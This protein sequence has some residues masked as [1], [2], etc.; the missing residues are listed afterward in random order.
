MLSDLSLPN[1]TIISLVETSSF[2]PGDCIF[3]TVGDVGG[4]ADGAER[5][6]DRGRN[7]DFCW[8]AEA[9][10]GFLAMKVWWTKMGSLEERSRLEALTTGDPRCLSGIFVVNA[11]AILAS[12]LTLS[13]VLSIH[14]MSSVLRLKDVVLLRA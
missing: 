1:G 5:V 7:V 11:L 12:G 6:G 4:E 8:L 13:A 14:E 2:A 10:L 3:A 9:M